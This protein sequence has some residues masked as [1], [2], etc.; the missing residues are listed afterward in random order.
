MDHRSSG[1]FSF[2]YLNIWINMLKRSEFSRKP[3]S[4]ALSSSVFHNEIK[5]SLHHNN[6]VTRIELDSSQLL[7]RFSNR[8]CYNTTEARLRNIPL[9]WD[10]IIT[11]CCS[12]ATNWQLAVL[13][14]HYFTCCF[15]PLLLFWLALARWAACKTQRLF[16]VHLCLK[17]SFFFLMALLW[18]SLLHQ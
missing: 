9:H 8:L 15:R 13:P 18:L 7:V 4:E 3:T 1:E 14:I 6:V 12:Y 5:S 2:F 16:G 17:R 10:V 11:L